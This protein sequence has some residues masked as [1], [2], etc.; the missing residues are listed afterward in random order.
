MPTSARDDLGIV[1][2]RVHAAKRKFTATAV[3]SNRAGL[4]SR[5]TA[6]LPVSN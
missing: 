3:L 1:P 5:I 2:Y 4:G 6:L